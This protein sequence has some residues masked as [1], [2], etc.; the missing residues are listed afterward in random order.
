VTFPRSRR[1]FPR[2]RS[3]LRLPRLLREPSTAVGVLGL[4]ALAAVAVGNVASTRPAARNGPRAYL[5]GAGGWDRAPVPSLGPRIVPDDEVLGERVPVED[6]G[7]RALDAFHEALARAAAGKGP[8][9]ILMLGASHTAS[10]ELTGPL[11]ER[12]QKAFGDAGPGMVLPVTPFKWYAHRDLELLHRGRFRT[13]RLDRFDRQRRRF[14]LPGHAGLSGFAIESDRAGAWTR[15]SPRRREGRGTRF[16]RIE[17][18]YLARPGGGRFDLRVDGQGVARVAT[19]ARRVG[20]RRHVVEVPDGRHRVGIRIRTEEPVRLLGLVLERDR[21]GVVVDAL[22]IPGSRAADQLPGDPV[23]HRA[24][25]RLRDPDLVVLA[26]GTNE[27]LDRPVSLVDYEADLRQLLSRVRDAVPDASCL[28]VG[29]SDRPEV[30][31]DGR[32]RPRPRAAQVVEVQR[33]LSADYGCGFFDLIRLQGGHGAMARWVTHDP[34]MGRD[35]YTHF[36]RRGY[37]R[38]AELLESALLAG[39]RPA[40]P[41]NPPAR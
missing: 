36:T 17:V 16:S 20:V 29:P 9:R 27:A 15:I 21:P 38:V 41:S 30:E 32:V 11:R 1:R 5:P 37:E 12:F 14:G 23:T 26:W 24:H 18:H 34:P 7:G 39:Y 2:L 35:D 6:P 33:R 40:S 4:L 31:D 22:G 28:L 8:A 10:D 13:V 25:L 3:R 19:A